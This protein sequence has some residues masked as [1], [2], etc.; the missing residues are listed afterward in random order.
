MDEAHRA[1]AFVSTLMEELMRA[2]ACF[3]IPV[4]AEKRRDD[5]A[6][7]CFDWLMW[8]A[9][10]RNL[11]ARPAGAP[12]PV[13]VAVKHHK[14]EDQ[15]PEEFAELWGKLRGSDLV[16]MQ[17]A[18]HWNMASKRM[19]VQAGHGE[20]LIVLGGGEGVLHLANLYH[21]AGKPVIPLNFKLCPQNTGARRL[22]DFGLSESNTHRL[23]RT[24]G[25]VKPHGWLNR[26]EVASKKS[27]TD[28]VKDVMGLL[29]ALVPPLAFVV[30]L[31]DSSHADYND[32][33][34]FFDA[35]AQPIIEGELHYKMTVVDGKQVQDYSRVDQEVFNKLHRSQL[36]IADITGLRP[37][38]FLELG[39]ALGR[40]LR[41]VLTAKEGTTPPFDI[42]TLAGHR[43]KADG[44]V[45]DRQRAFRDHMV[46]VRTRPPLVQADPLIP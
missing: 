28:A 4:D 36:V 12:A 29:A 19:E 38:C 15:I 17:S 6:K 42:H 8:E 11:V 16:H 23:F 24:D 43:W 31:M 33:Q 37:N 18:A 41:T 1:R 45:A 25:V 30:R 9:I 5:G 14:N 44:L 22:F 40:P 39:Y 34:N 3:V 13:A 46:S 10:E 35:V 27:A 21:D 7:I 2:G 32:V 20:I 26:L